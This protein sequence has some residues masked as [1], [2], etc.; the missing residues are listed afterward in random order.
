MKNWIVVA[1]GARARILEES[2]PAAG[3]VPPR[4][5]HVVD[6][7]HPAS[8]SKGT[9]LAS[10]APG[11][12]AGGGHGLGSAKYVPRTD[13]REKERDRFAHD[14]AR[15]LDDGVA[16]GRCAGIVIVASNPLLGELKSHLGHQARKAVLRTLAA[17]YTT[18]DDEQL[19][20]RLAE[21]GAGGAREH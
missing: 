18:L 10:D 5:V 17:D 3:S 12:V 9:E 1:N 16:D 20:A 11:R 2:D 4:F 7:V 13:P 15:W 19:A 8:R 14:V 21:H 6:L